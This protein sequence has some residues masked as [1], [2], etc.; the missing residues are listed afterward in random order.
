[1]KVIALGQLK[2]AVYVGQGDDYPARLSVADP[3]ND[4]LRAVF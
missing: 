1:M 2:I 4:F 3:K